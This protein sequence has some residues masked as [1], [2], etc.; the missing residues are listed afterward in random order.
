M[1][2]GI[3][4]NRRICHSSHF[5]DA[6]LPSICPTRKSEPGSTRLPRLD[7]LQPTTYPTP[8]VSD[9]SRRSTYRH[10]SRT[11]RSRCCPQP[12]HTEHTRQCT[13]ES[14]RRAGLRRPISLNAAAYYDSWIRYQREVLLF[15]ARHYAR[16][17]KSQ[18][19]RAPWNVPT[20]ESAREGHTPRVKL[21][22]APCALVSRQNR[23]DAPST[24]SSV[25]RQEYYYN[26]R[27]KATHGKN[28]MS[29][30]RYQL[31]RSADETLTKEKQQKCGKCR[32]VGHNSRTC[33]RRS[34]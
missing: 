9:V 28:H 27:F 5:E 33:Q 24:I 1:H 25:C 32:A 3:T 12:K 17:E 10:P 31:D 29:L 23:L 2:P 16:V 4:M 26:A 20:H 6:R 18:T 30:Q 15:W 22:T 19:T 34:R 21:E 14:C 11:P 8:T 13:G 7:E